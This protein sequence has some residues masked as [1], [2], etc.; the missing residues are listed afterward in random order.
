MSSEGF[1]G[2][3]VKCPNCGAAL[4]TSPDALVYVCAHC[5]WA[6][7]DKGKIAFE[8]VGP[9]READVVKAVVAFLSRRVKGEVVI[10]EVVTM[11][12]PFWAVGLRARTSY[13]GYRTEVRGS[14]KHREV[15][16][17]P[18][19]D[20]L[21]ETVL[22]PV[23]ARA[24]ESFF[25]LEEI[26]SRVVE[27]FSLADSLDPVAL[28]KLV[29]ILNVEISE[30]EAVDSAKSR[31]SEDHRGRVEALANEVFDCYTDFEVLSK[32]LVFYPVTLIKYEHKG[33]VYR[34][35]SD[36]STS[37]EP[38]DR[39]LKA[40]LPMAALT[41]LYYA[42]T[43]DLAVMALAL[44]SS[45]VNYVLASE[46]SKDNNLTILVIVIVALSGFIGWKG[47]NLA[48]KEE[49]VWRRGAGEDRLMD[50]DELKEVV[51]RT[52]RFR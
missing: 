7:Y 29:R 40:E 12:L 23:Y 31:V 6:G 13:N 49:R 44:A 10:R 22:V 11:M 47:A 27:N 3:A 20:V 37:C 25:G 15:I 24:F 41:R 18:V 14:G 16:Y 39:V 32:K 28:V 1:L 48:T 46:W 17:F 26:K 42:L 33:K 4:E 9:S 43:S 21:D 35:C 30:E 50:L 34:V 5:G 8:G 38:G 51:E 52:S 2:S 36:A 19:R 45:P